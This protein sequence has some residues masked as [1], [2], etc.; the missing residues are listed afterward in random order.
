MSTPP[1]RS[2][3]TPFRKNVLSEISRKSNLNR[4]TRA[5]ES[6]VKYPTPTPTSKISDSESLAV[7]INGNRGAQ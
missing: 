7:K 4:T 2:K 6:E 3:R 1:R 5:A